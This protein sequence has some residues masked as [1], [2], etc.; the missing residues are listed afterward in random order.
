MQ[1]RSGWYKDQ[2]TKFFCHKLT[3][4]NTH[5]FVNF[6]QRRIQQLINRAHPNQIAIATR[7][8]GPTIAQNNIDTNEID[9]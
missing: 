1:L 6:L 3:A 9:Y 7:N 8:R 4:S 2:A 5:L